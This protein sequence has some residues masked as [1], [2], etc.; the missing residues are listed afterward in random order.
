MNW[1]AVSAFQ[2][3]P[4]GF[5]LNVIQ[6][7]A[8]TRISLSTVYR[9]SG[10]AYIWDAW[11]EGLDLSLT[12]AFSPRPPLYLEAPIPSSTKAALLLTT[13]ADHG[14]NGSMLLPQR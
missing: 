14:V 4:P 13:S 7:K 12:W 9:L 8:G 11:Q 1:D 5:A 3:T 2:A 6:S 10:P